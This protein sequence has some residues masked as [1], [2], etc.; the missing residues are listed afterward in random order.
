V[1]TGWSQNAPPIKIKISVMSN[2][3]PNAFNIFNN[4]EPRVLPGA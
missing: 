2:A 4:Y 1:M 3:R